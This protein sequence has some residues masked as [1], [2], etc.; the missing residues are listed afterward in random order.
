[1]PTFLQKI[2]AAQAAKQAE[3]NRITVAGNIFKTEL[4]MLSMELMMDLHASCVM[5][6]HYPEE[7]HV[8]G[9]TWSY[10]LFRWGDVEEADSYIRYARADAE[11]GIVGTFKRMEFVIDNSM[12]FGEIRIKARPFNTLEKLP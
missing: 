8:N 3:D 9:K 5:S 4:Q 12:H 6:G 10:M 11:A 7:V 2:Q 1:M